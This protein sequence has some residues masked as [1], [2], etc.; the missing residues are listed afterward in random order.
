MQTLDHVLT[1]MP[2]HYKGDFVYMKDTKFTPISVR[3]AK[4]MSV[5]FHDTENGLIYLVH[6]HQTIGYV[7]LIADLNSGAQHAIPVMTVSLRDSGLPGIKQAHHLRIRESFAKRNIATVWYQ[8]YVEH[9]GKIAS[10]AEHL[11]GG[12]ALWKSFIKQSGRA[13]KVAL[14]DVNTG[15]GTP[16]TSATPDEEIWSTDASKKNLIL[17]MSRN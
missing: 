17:V 15:A 2:Q 12:K 3:N 13:F 10:D 5:L 7:F 16:V 6:P 11:E 4:D 1:E 14:V 8:K 9:F